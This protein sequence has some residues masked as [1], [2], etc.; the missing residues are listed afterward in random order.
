MAIVVEVQ[1]NAFNSKVSIVQKLL[2][3]SD[4]IVKVPFAMKLEVSKKRLYDNPEIGMSFVLISVLLK[5]F[6]AVKVLQEISPVLLMDAN[7]LGTSIE[8]V[9]Q[10][11][12]P[13]IVD[14]FVLLVP[15]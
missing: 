1:T 12:N 8:F 10:K 6:V 15:A 3:G 9:V 2:T 4:G 13:P 11:S 5:I 14:G 7:L